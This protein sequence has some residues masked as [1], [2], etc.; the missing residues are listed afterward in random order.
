MNCSEL[1]DS[2]L[3]EPAKLSA[4]MAAHL[5]AC[6]ECTVYA[7]ELKKFESRLLKA[8]AV[9]V[10]PQPLPTLAELGAHG[11]EA[12]L[13]PIGAAR[14][15]RR[16]PV[17]FAIA[18]SGVL[19]TVVI[20]A[21]LTVYPRY[22]L[23]TALVGHVADEPNSWAV[24]DTSLPDEAVAYALKRSGVALDPGGPRISYAQSCTFRGYR[25][26]HLVVQTDHGPITVMALR[27]E[28]VS[29]AISIDEDGYRGIV[30]PDGQGALAVISR[31][32]GD[33]QVLAAVAAQAV[34]AIHFLD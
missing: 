16:M 22:A 2:L 1:R 13:T 19:A 15:P 18:A 21:L 11:A 14:R 30:V 7:A 24:T 10:D 28:H 5:A 4:E 32:T 17:W 31:G 26:P 33:R 6:A 8:L 25:V 34:A 9:R 27:H 12:I 20:A 29:R 3:A 23:A